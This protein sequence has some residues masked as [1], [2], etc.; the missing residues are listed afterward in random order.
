MNVFHNFVS[1]SSFH[2]CSSA[3]TFLCCY[4]SLRGAFCPDTFFPFSSDICLHLQGDT[5]PEAAGESI[6]KARRG[7]RLESANPLLRADSSW[8]FHNWAHFHQSTTCLLGKMTSISGIIWHTN[9]NKT[10]IL[11]P[12]TKT[13]LQHL[14]PSG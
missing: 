13:E 10:L 8:E 7:S 6:M 2:Q 3:S 9:K 11:N 1:F 5:R 4:V 12:K 14:Q